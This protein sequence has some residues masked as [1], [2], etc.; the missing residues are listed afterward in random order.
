MPTPVIRHK[1]EQ[2]QDQSIRLIPLTQGQ[3]AIVSASDYE[4]LR[5]TNWC[6]WWNPHTGSFYAKGR[7]V[8]GEMIG[9][10]SFLVPCRQG[11]VPD[12]INGN[13]LDHRRN[14]LQELPHSIN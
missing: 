13:T 8:C 5:Q 12:H 9:M 14:N 10:H 2:P 3:N 4:M 1:V 6:A 7:P 11:Y